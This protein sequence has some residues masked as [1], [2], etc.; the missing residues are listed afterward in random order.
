MATKKPK[1]K[2]CKKDIYEREILEI[3][4]TKFITKIK[5]IFSYYSGIQSAQFYNLGLEKSETL[6][7]AMQDNRTKACQ[8]LL[9]KWLHSDNPTLQ[10]AA[11]KILCED[12]DRKK[13]SMAYTDITSKDQGIQP[14][15]QIIIV[16][17]NEKRGEK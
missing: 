12:E 14:I 1:E 3:I 13:L 9:S 7:K 8:S 5:Q 2:V 10:M 16:E 4:K 11:Y 17:S 6:L 15:P